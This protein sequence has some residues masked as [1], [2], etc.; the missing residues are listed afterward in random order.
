VRERTAELREANHQLELHNRF[1]RETFGRYVSNDR[2]QFAGIARTAT[3]GRAKAQSDDLMSDLQGFT[4][5]CRRL[6]PE[7]VEHH[8]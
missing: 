3:I 2:R 7:R 1:I 5:L 6:A 4:S 8:Q